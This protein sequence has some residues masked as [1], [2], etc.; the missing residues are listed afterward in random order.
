LARGADLA[1]VDKWA[2]ESKKNSENWV[3]G[4]CRAKFLWDEG[5]AHGRKFIAQLKDKFLK[6]RTYMI[7]LFFSFRFQLIRTY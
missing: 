5:T 4:S 2:N 7:L 1:D 3:V 6:V